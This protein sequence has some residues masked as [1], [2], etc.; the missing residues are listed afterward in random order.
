MN[1]IAQRPGKRRFYGRRKGR[2]L[3]K[4]THI[5]GVL[6]R[7]R[8]RC[9]R[10]AADPLRCFPT[11]ERVW[12][13]SVLAAAS[14]TEQARTH[15][16]AGFIGCEVFLNGITTL[17]AQIVAASQ[18]CRSPGDARSAG[19]VAGFVDRVF[20]LFPDPWPSRHAADVSSSRQSRFLARLMKPGAGSGR[21]R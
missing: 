16:D 3:R 4:G 5:H 10:K 9:C 6:P 17:L 21:E 1:R 18:T 20:L 2:P 15:S 12:L 11:A 13:E 14:T 8:S 19:C 7:L